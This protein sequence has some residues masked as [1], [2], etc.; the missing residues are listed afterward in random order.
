MLVVASEKTVN[1]SYGLFEGPWR[2]VWG[3]CM[4]QLADDVGK[5][6]GQ[7]PIASQFRRPIDVSDEIFLTKIKGETSRVGEALNDA[8]H[9]TGIA[10]VPKP[11]HSRTT[12]P[13]DG[14]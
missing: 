8:V 9:V 13:A 7:F 14:T 3:I 6:H 1:A 4:P 11:R 2:Y 5:F 10:E 12:T